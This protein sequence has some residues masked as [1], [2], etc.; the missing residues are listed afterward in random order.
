MLARPRVWWQKIK[1]HPYAT[2]FIVLLV[3]V[4]I[5][6]IFLA[7]RFG[8]DWTGF[9]SATN[10]ITITSTSKGNY[11]AA[12]SQP[13]KS[14]W[15]WLGLLAAL[16]IPAVVGLGAAWY[17]AQQGKVSDRENTDNQR[18]TALQAYIDKMSELLL[19]GRLR[20][21]AE[22]DEVRTIGRVRTLTVLPRL[23][24]ERKG[25]VLQFLAE[26]GLIDKRR[27]IIDLDGA[28]LSGANLSRVVLGGA[29]LSRANLSG[30]NL[31]KVLLLGA[32]LSGA[33]LQSADL[34]RANLLGADLSGADLDKPDWPGKD[35]PGANLSGADLSRAKLSGAKL[36]EANLSGASLFRANLFNANLSAAILRGA[37]LSDV[38]L[39]RTNLIEADL[40]EAFFYKSLPSKGIFYEASL[41]EADLTRAKL[42]NAHITKEQLKKVKSLQGAIMPDGSKNP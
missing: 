41:T 12:I 42:T 22:E 13:L 16:A 38:N 25:S 37:H 27:S 24:N 34:S 20:D 39:T 8:W 35:L 17:T 3:L 26:S 30:A 33:T 40:S 4:L 18:E 21:S 2:G 9:N 7:Y 32:D 28:D 19:H 29:N 1:Q 5:L 6:F 10:Q 36:R 11:T 23:D 15:D 14:L 31:S